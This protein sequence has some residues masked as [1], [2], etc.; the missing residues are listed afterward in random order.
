MYCLIL[1]SVCGYA[2]TEDTIIQ[3][4]LDF[5]N[6]LNEHYSNK[7]TSPLK[8]KERRKFK[9]HRFYPVDL[10]YRVSARVV[11][12]ENADTI[13]MPT[14]AGTAKNFIRFAEL[15]FEIRD[16]S[17][18]LIA[19][20]RAKEGH[21]NYLFIPFTDATSGNESYGGGRYIDLDM[22]VGDEVILDFNKA[23]NPYCAYTTGWFCP[24]PP[25]EN[26]LNIAIKAGLMAPEHH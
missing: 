9:T 4:I 11:L 6:E 26:S 21:D 2:Q 22:P 1:S 17:C 14:S 24:I 12:I 7:E 13:V 10:K 8:K 18:V 5:R 23:Y 16:T 25:R 3:E 15:H 19:Y 20:Q